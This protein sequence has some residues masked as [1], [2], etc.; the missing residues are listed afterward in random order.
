MTALAFTR[1]SRYLLALMRSLLPAAAVLAL[2]CAPALDVADDGPTVPQVTLTGVRLR[3]YR[4]A[5]L[6]ADGT[7]KTLTYQ[8][9]TSEFV[10]SAVA[11]RLPGRG[12]DLVASPAGAGGPARQVDLTA[13]TARGTLSSRQ[14]DGEGGVVVRTESGLTGKTPRAHFDGAASSASGTDEV[15]VEGSGYQLSSRGFHLD[16]PTERFTFDAEVQS[17]FG[18]R[19]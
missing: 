5:E 8:R 3:H 7:A 11:M 17:R 14:A 12:A 19:P 6:V 9:S 13:P 15:A 4:G 18:A 16:L 1:R 10:A 2:S